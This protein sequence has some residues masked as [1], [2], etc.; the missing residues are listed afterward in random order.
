MVFLPVVIWFSPAND[1]TVSR[2]APGFAITIKICPASAIA[3][4]IAGYLDI[5]D[6][7]SDKLAKRVKLVFPKQGKGIIGGVQEGGRL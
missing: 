7:I 5:K 3:A 1:V 4:R 2:I 6:A